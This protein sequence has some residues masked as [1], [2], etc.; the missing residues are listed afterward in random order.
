MSGRRPVFLNPGH[1]RR[2]RL[3]DAARLLPVGGGFLILLPILWA[4][5]E[6]ARNDTAPDGI[7]LF[8]VWAVLIGLAALLSRRLL[9][10]DGTAG[11]DLPKPGA[12][13]D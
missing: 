6:T 12:A 3:R 5:G 8:A 9:D 2:R 10:K 11:T 13:E 4:P 7:Y 1:Y